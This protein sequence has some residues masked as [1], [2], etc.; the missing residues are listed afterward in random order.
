[1]KVREN[2][3]L[4]AG[5]RSVCL[6]DSLGALSHPSQSAVKH[7]EKQQ[8]ESAGAAGCSWLCK[9]GCHQPV[10]CGGGG[11]EA[12][13]LPQRELN[14]GGT[15]ARD[16]RISGGL[17]LNSQ[18]S[19]S[20]SSNSR[21]RAILLLTLLFIVTSDLLEAFFPPRY[22]KIKTGLARNPLSATRER[23]LIQQLCCSH[24]Q[25]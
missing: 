3:I 5:M 8:S 1:M 14:T 19:V 6:I 16:K 21:H 13:F 18:P 23:H 11:K 10:S 4:G 7:K 25:R 24:Y 2:K 15:F 20:K 9:E 12:V 17:L 22:L